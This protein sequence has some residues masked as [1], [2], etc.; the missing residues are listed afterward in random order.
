MK[1]QVVHFRV[2]GDFI[3]EH[4]RSL[5]Q[6]DN[7]AGALDILL[8]GF[9]NKQ[10]RQAN[11]PY[12]LLVARGIMRMNED[13][14]GLVNEE[15]P[16]TTHR[17]MELLS[18]ADNVARL[19]KRYYEQYE[20]V[21]ATRMFISNPR[22]YELD[23][24]DV[25]Y[26]QETLE[27]QLTELN[28]RFD[29]IRN[30]CTITGTP[31]TTSPFSKPEIDFRQLEVDQTDREDESRFFVTRDPA[32]TAR[33]KQFEE[34]IEEKAGAG[35]A[36]MKGLADILDVDP[37][38]VGL[39]AFM[40][41]TR[42]PEPPFEPSDITKFHSGWVARNGDFYPCKGEE[43][44]YLSQKLVE[45]FYSAEAQ[46]EGAYDKQRFLEKRGWA[47]LSLGRVQYGG[48]FE[49]E[50]NGT[51]YTVMSPKQIKTFKKWFEN[52]GKPD[53]NYN[54]RRVAWAEFLEDQKSRYK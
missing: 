48:P 47:K 49:P 27:I 25:T 17:G 39:D 42:Q 37:S 4:V 33:R 12:A 23:L 41:K 34:A 3:T 31:F 38:L 24:D 22:R 52:T 1:K 32:T 15:T 7:P 21:E 18:V 20:S 36:M 14:T 16:V 45:K 13:A 30:L 19:E 9:E 40:A 29:A 54:G 51:D 26:Y 2:E 6:E 43:H 8:D 5:W 28:K 44:H 46:Q 11:L 35:D 53:F 50:P 10:E